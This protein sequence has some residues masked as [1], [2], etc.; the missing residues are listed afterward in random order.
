[1]RP[2]LKTFLKA[3]IYITKRNQAPLSLKNNEIKLFSPDAIYLNSKGSVKIK[4]S[5]KTFILNRRKVKL[6]LSFSRTSLLKKYLKECRSNARNSLRFSRELEFC[7][8]LEKRLDI[9][10]YR[11]GFAT[12]ISEARHLISHKK[13]KI[14][15]ISNTS[16]SRFLRKG[17]IITFVPSVQ[18]YIKKRLVK[19][20]HSRGF[21]F[22]TFENLE[23]NIKLLKIILLTERLGIPQQI[24]HYSFSINWNNVLNS[25]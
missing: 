18:A 16:F 12:S 8:L 3:G 20:I 11:L 25:Y 10:L 5:F 4:E 9:L 1:M 23:V 19:E 17:D 21:F 7:S 24:Q 22:N 2:K 14:N 15:N 6:L 13:V